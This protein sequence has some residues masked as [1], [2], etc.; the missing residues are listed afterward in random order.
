M[1]LRNKIALGVIS[2]AAIPLLVLVSSSVV[3]FTQIKLQ[4]SIYSLGL[5]LESEA[6]QLSSF[7][8]VRKAEVAALSEASEV[9]SMDFVSMQ[10]LLQNELARLNPVYEKFIIG[11]PTGEFNN[12]SGGN[13]HQRMLRTFDDTDPEAKS[14]SIA[15]RDYWQNTLGKN[16]N[17]IKETVVSEPMISYTTEVKQVVV[18]STIVR[19]QQVVGMLGG[20]LPWKNIEH[21]I[22]AMKARFEES[23]GSG[24]RFFLVSPSGYYWYHWNPAKVVHYKKDTHGRVILN[25]IGEKVAVRSSLWEDPDLTLRKNAKM[26][27]GTN[28]GYI[29][30]ASSGE[31][32]GHYLLFNKVK[33]SGYILGL[34]VPKTI[35]STAVNDVR[36]YLIGLAVFVILLLVLTSYWLGYRISQP[37]T[38]LSALTQAI[39]SGKTVQ[40]YEPIGKDET[41]ELTKNVF[42]MLDVLRANEKA[43]KES[44]ERFS[45]AMAGANDGLWDWDIQRKSVYY[46]PRWKSMLGYEPHELQNRFE[47]FQDL[48]IPSDV[49]RMDEALKTLFL[50]N[51]SS[52]E[53]E[54]SLQHKNGH[55]V[56]VLCRAYLV[57]NN[58]G[59]PQRLVGTHVDITE[60]KKQEA[61]NKRLN[62]KLEA[63]V[64]ERTRELDERNAQLEAAMKIAEEASRAKSHFLANMSHELRTPLNSIIGFN[65]RMGVYLEQGRTERLSEAVATVERNAVHLLELINQVLDFAKVEEGKLEL[66]KSDFDLAGLLDECIDSFKPIAAQ[67]GL[68]VQ[69]QYLWRGT[70]HADKLRVRQLVINLISNAIKFTPKG[71]V[72]CRLS[73][74]ELEGKPAIRLDVIDTGIGIEAKK[75]DLLFTK[76]TQFSR[77][78][79]EGGSAGTGLG[80]SISK[81]I[82]VLHGGTIDVESEFNKGSR[83]TVFLPL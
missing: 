32:K 6:V 61:F 42:T 53:I 11:H 35:V 23:V 58:E 3:Q 13:P 82:V 24:A 50:G 15:Q 79:V 8:A 57:R 77:D 73:N 52:F 45:L 71:E 1:N 55:Q 19:D 44:D 30:M 60:R 5:V 75:M 51:D 64:Q 10:G 59:E 7:F 27:L 2:A 31:H 14:R 18:A 34:F 21:Y 12:T 29:E 37:I 4:D 54:C 46:S 17:G 63:H 33:S 41:A 72:R 48:L 49:P 16:D 78:H 25:E 67:K 36:M 39:R 28:K 43:L 20:A 62:E 74:A 70:I 66:E 40:P 80:L 26:I 76:F 83:F 9:K 81:E 56:N 22:H 68:E 38:K 65:R 47:V 69:R